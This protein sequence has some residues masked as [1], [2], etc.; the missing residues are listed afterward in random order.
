MND[1]LVNRSVMGVFPIATDQEYNINNDIISINNNSNA[2][3]QNYNPGKNSVFIWLIWGV[4]LQ[5][6][7]I[8]C[9]I[10]MTKSS[11]LCEWLYLSTMF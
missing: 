4:F 8:E 11:L 3:Y 10:R 7:E 5:V 9:Q 2:T 1:L 6:P